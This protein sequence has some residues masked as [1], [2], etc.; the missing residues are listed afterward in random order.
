MPTSPHNAVEKTFV[1][2]FE[3]VKKR[4]EGLQAHQP[5]LKENVR[6]IAERA[7]GKIVPGGYA[8]IRGGSGERRGLFADERR[9]RDDEEEEEEYYDPVL[10]ESR[11]NGNH[12]GGIVDN[13]RGGGVG[14]YDASPGADLDVDW[15]EWDKTLRRPTSI[16]GRQR[17]ASVGV[18]EAPEPDRGSPYSS[19]LDGWQR[20]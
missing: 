2:M 5:A 9:D 3:T 19:G 12:P 8:K 1:H 16:I 15:S 7:E 13:D 10:V 17:A 6:R 20:L 14:M 11:W 4:A 18:D